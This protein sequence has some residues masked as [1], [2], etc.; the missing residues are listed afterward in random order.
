MLHHL[1]VFV[2]RTVLTIQLEIGKDASVKDCL[3]LDRLEAERAQAAPGGPRAAA[4]RGPGCEGS[5]RGPGS[6]RFVGAPCLRHSATL[7]R[8][9]K[10]V[11]RGS[12]A[13]GHASHSRCLR[14]SFRRRFALR[15]R[16]YR[17]FAGR[18]SAGRMEEGITQV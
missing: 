4:R 9:G 2:L 12:G 7:R 16:R 17:V 5:R 18:G 1:V 3:R 14:R 8:F 13:F 11:S 10:P 6:P 15:Q